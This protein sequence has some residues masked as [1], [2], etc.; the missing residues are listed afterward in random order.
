MW[1]T[2][3]SPPS[4]RRHAAG[5]NYPAGIIAALFTD[6][7]GFIQKLP[8]TLVAAFRATLEEIAD[9]ELLLH[10]VDIC[11]PQRH[12]NQAEAVHANPG[13]DRGRSRADH[14]RPEQD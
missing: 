7:V 3:C 10:V 9:A 13:R 2:S 6:T 4:T 1:P 11:S 12:G 14:H 5:S 8:T